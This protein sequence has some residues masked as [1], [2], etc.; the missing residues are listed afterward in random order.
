[1]AVKGGMTPTQMFGPGGRFGPGDE[2]RRRTPQQIAGEKRRRKFTEEKL[3]AFGGRNPLKIPQK[4]REKI[5]KDLRE[6][7]RQEKKGMK[8]EKGFGTHV[9]V[10]TAAQGQVSVLSPL[11]FK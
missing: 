7:K 1:M 2:P 8:K 3:K 5:I 10:R 11:G 9:D 6:K 4:E